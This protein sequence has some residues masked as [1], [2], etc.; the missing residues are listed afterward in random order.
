METRSILPPLPPLPEPLPGSGRRT[1]QAKTAAAQAVSGQSGVSD[2]VVD[3]DA[4]NSGDYEEDLDDFQA[5]DDII[6]DFQPDMSFSNVGPDGQ[7][8]SGSMSPNGTANGKGGRGRKPK[9]VVAAGVPKD[10]PD[11]QRLR[12]ENHVRRPSSFFIAMLFEAYTLPLSC[13]LFLRH[14]STYPRF[15]ANHRKT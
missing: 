13:L 9:T 15:S 1:R 7:S 8:L 11:Y 14:S 2:I 4:E 12:K 10:S 6:Y 5:E 3:D